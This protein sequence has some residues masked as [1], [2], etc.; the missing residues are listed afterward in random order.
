MSAT[1]LSNTHI[2]V[3]VLQNKK[4]LETLETIKNYKKLGE[5]KKLKNIFE[6]N[7]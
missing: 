3:T 7:S 2:K 5:I 4:Q 1:L 6:K